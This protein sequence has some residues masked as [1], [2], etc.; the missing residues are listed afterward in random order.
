MYER[1]FKLSNHWELDWTTILD[2]LYFYLWD[3][4]PFSMLHIFK[5]LTVAHGIWSWVMH[6]NSNWSNILF[7]LHVFTLPNCMQAYKNVIMANEYQSSKI[8]ESLY[9]RC[10]DKMDQLQVLRLPSM[11]K[12]NA[13]F[14]QCN[15]SFAHECVGPSKANYEQRMMKVCSLIWS[16]ALVSGLLESTLK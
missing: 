1:I 2:E 12:F 14:L 15:Q 13:G 10:E 6:N 8:C 4:F 11:A 3:C 16:N 5:F 9:T 7:H